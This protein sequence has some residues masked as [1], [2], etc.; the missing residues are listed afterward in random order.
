MTLMILLALAVAGG[1]FSNLLVETAPQGISMKTN[2]TQREALTLPFRRLDSFRTGPMPDEVFT[3]V[4]RKRLRTL[5]VWLAVLLLA[6]LANHRQE[7]FAGALVLTLDGWYLVTIAAVDLEYRLVLNRMLLAGLFLIAASLLVLG[8]PNLPSA[9]TGAALGFAV[10]FVLAL[11]WPGALGMGDVKLAGWV[12]LL[13]GFPGIVPAL[14]I[15]I[16]AGGIGAVFKL[17]LSGFRRG[18]TIAYAPYLALGA[19]AFIYYRT[20]I[21]QWFFH[22]P[23]V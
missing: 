19:I 13:A 20:E 23:L 1:W 3:P 6:W 8:T 17:A 12:G 18:T 9:L 5:L 2:W 15:A 10:F 16:L 11:V 21:L 22:S 14:F 7:T 4:A